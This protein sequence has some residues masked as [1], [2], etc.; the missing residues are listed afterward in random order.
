MSSPLTNSPDVKSIITA[1]TERNVEWLE[2]LRTQRV[3]SPSHLMFACAT[4]LGDQEQV[5]DFMKGVAGR[6]KR[7]RF[8]DL[9]IKLAQADD[10]APVAEPV[11]VQTQVVVEEPVPF[12]IEPPAEETDDAPKRRRRSSTAAAPA[13]PAAA[14]SVDLSAITD[15][16]TQVSGMIK[17]LTKAF[18][19]LETR[20]ES[21]ERAAHS[22]ERSSVELLKSSNVISALV[23]GNRARLET[24]RE[25]LVAAEL[26]LV[27]SGGLPTAAMSDVVN[28]SWPN[29]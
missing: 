5:A 16:L 8:I 29:D 17:E 13:A 15:Q 10:A 12:E 19:T 18:Y 20:I 2:G 1:I 4:I 28:A 27:I 14:A 6:D 9:A 21:V 23:G 25:A 7:D 26:E 24:L 22:A 3:P 11:Q